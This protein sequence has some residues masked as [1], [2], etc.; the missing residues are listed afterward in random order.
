MGL[1]ASFSIWSWIQRWSSH[2]LFCTRL[3][4]S[5]SLPKVYNT[6]TKC[7]ILW[8]RYPAY[9]QILESEKEGIHHTKFYSMKLS[10]R[11]GLSGSCLTPPPEPPVL[12]VKILP[13]ST[14]RRPTFRVAMTDR[15]REWIS[16]RGSHYQRIYSYP[17]GQKGSPSMSNT[18]GTWDPLL[19]ASR[20]LCC[21]VSLEEWKFNPG[22]NNQS[23]VPGGCSGSGQ[24][25]S[26]PPG[27]RYS[28]EK[29][30]VDL[31]PSILRNINA[32]L[33]CWVC[34]RGMESSGLV[35]P[36]VPDIHSP[37][38]K[39]RLQTLRKDVKA[40]RKADYVQKLRRHSGI[41]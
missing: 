24:L 10:L 3:G 22:G 25:R 1:V 16:Y 33:C 31:A 41:Q 18:I 8:D 34:S 36:Q 28:V 12:L 9:D 29:P 39:G 37:S 11:V 19:S 38:P 40:Q 17:S 35:E 32:G 14:S 20:R 30:L 7:R 13:Y 15:Q 26:T 4:R 6:V 23:Q 21:P 27:D 5:K 2:C